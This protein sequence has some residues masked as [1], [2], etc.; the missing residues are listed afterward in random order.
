MTLAHLA[1]LDGETAR[2]DGDRHGL[3]PVGVHGAVLVVEALQ[4]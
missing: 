1:P 2:V 3:R 4:L